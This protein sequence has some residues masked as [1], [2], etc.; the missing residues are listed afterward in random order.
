MTFSPKQKLK[1]QH[2]PTFMLSIRITWILI[3]YWNCD[4][5]HFYLVPSLKFTRAMEIIVCDSVVFQEYLFEI[6][7]VRACIHSPEGIGNLMEQDI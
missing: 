5:F 7:V 3:D 4:S 1:Q 2:I 6:S